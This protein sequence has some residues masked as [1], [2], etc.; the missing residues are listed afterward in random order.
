V[1]HK[2]AILILVLVA[3]AA[4]LAVFALN[5]G[6]PVNTTAVR[7]DNPLFEVLDE[8]G[9][10]KL[11]SAD[12]KGKVVFLNFWASW[13]DPCKE[14]MPSMDALYKTLRTNGN[15][16]MVTVL[17]RDSLTNASD[18]MKS[19]GFAFPVYTDP[20]E[21]SS[22]NF[23]V[24]GVPETYL[25]DKKGVVRKRV[26]GAADWGSAEEKALINLLLSE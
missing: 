17:Y 20:A 7:A 2:K 19:K 23:G 11:S 16:A 12:L 8:A 3:C 14:E 25:I 9:G 24:T 26:I 4:L 6:T 22:R 18:Y 15:F 21:A 5:Q 13:C 10:K 1:K